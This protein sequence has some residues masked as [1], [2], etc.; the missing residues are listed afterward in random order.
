MIEHPRLGQNSPGYYLPKPVIAH[1]LS[2][3]KEPRAFYVT[4]LGSVCGTYI[5]VSNSDPIEL[6]EG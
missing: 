5:K 4:D 1:I 3:I 6:Q 2:F